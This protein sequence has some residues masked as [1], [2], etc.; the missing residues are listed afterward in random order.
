MFDLIGEPEDMEYLYSCIADCSLEQCGESYLISGRYH[1]AF[2]GHPFDPH[3]E[4]WKVMSIESIFP[5]LALISCPNATPN[6]V[7]ECVRRGCLLY[8][9]DKSACVNALRATIE[10]VC[11]SKRVR[12]TEIN[13][14]RRRRLS[15]HHRIGLLKNSDP[16]VLEILLAAK[17]IGNS[18]SHYNAVVDDDSAMDAL[19][20][21]EYALELLYCDRSRQIQGMARRVNRRRGN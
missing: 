12:K 10:A 7:I 8:W 17:W 4:R 13:R 14:G 19:E 11:D 16:E 5:A 18:G 2:D 6:S 20:L 9:V 1:L 3:T 15:L 21:V